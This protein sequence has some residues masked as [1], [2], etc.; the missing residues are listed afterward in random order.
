[1]SQ[2][3]FETVPLTS[4]RPYARNARHHS[5]KQVKA[6]AAGMTEFGVTNPPLVDEA[7]EI[8]AGHGRLEAA[9]H[10]NLATIP[11]IRISGLSEV[12]KKALRL[13]DNKLALDSAWNL[14]LLSAEL[15]DLAITDFDI[16]LTGF[17]TIEVDKLTT[18]SLGLKE[19]DD[20]LPEPPAYPTA[21][22]G[23]VWALGDHLLA[24]GDARDVSVYRRLL[25]P[26]LAD[27]VITD[28][29]YN[30]PISG[31]VSG[32]GRV[33]HDEF[34]M[35][36]G[37]MSGTEFGSFL[38]TS[39]ALA[40]DSSR[41]GS[42]HYVFADWRMIGRLTAIGDE[43]FSSL[44]NIAV[45]A[46]PNGGMGSF[47][48]SQHE[49]VA[50]FKHG[51]APHSNNVQLGRMGRHRSNVWQYPGASGFSKTRKKDLED[52]PTVKPVALVADA[53][54]DATKPGD[55]I[56]DPF[57]GSGTTLIAAE[58]T[59]RRA[60]L[61]EIEPKYADVTL[62]RFQEHTGVEP[63][64]LPDRVPFSEVRAERNTNQKDAAE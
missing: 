35:A 4:L 36:S 50:I 15:T 61:I 11:I 17:E 8:I 30:V 59:K 31:H 16:T 25:G 33:T 49:M 44:L 57:G 51:N 27:M 14:E 58:L 2:I 24:I 54:R 26:K 53:I 6:I 39:L 46:K 7:G 12:Q 13:A 60:A 63:L 37:E 34:R 41:D 56:L 47:Y 9:K 42:L 64:L 5:R 18:P 55:L 40:R 32:K 48:R 62:R 38:A 23:D 3:Q 28:P 43:L 10:L 22:S 1:M 20:P 21:C 19:L 45:W 52:H 29:P